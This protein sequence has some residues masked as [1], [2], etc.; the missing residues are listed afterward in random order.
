MNVV[1][2]T[3]ASQHAADQGAALQGRGVYHTGQPLAARVL[4]DAVSQ[5]L[6]L[7]SVHWQVGAPDAAPRMA[8]GF[9]M[10]PGPAGEGAGEGIGLGHRSAN[11]VHDHQPGQ[12]PQHF[13][14]LLTGA[15]R[16]AREAT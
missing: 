16:V 14:D 3:P 10:A 9:R 7:A 11:R 5:A 2:P 8:D 12:E 15:Q 13:R 4:A 6:G 1:T